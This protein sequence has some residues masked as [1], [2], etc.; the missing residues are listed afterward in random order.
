MPLFLSYS[1]VLTPALA[2]VLVAGYA[3]TNSSV[4]PATPAQAATN[5]LFGLTD[6]MQL[7]YRLL[8][9]KGKTVGEINQRVVHLQQG[10]R[11]ESKK[12]MVPEQTAL[13]KS[14]LYDRKNVLIR[15]QDLTFRARRDTSFT[16]G[17][18]Y[19]NHDAM[20]SFRDRKIVYTPVPVAWPD[21]PT[22]GTELPDGGVTV[23]VS[24][25][26]VDIATV[27][28]TLRKR[29][30]VS[31]PTPLTTPAGTFACY[32]VESVRE[33]ATV[34]RPDMA[35][36]NT[37]KQVDFYAPGVGIV[38]TEQ[39]TKSGKLS[40]VQELTIRNTEPPSSMQKVKYKTKK[41]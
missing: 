17:M 29:R 31:G 2:L 1:S 6:K 23:N 4:P 36:R 18:A 30:V 8:D 16:D 11:E 24:S 9:A 14:G 37:S 25:S 3:Q 41:S 19:L 22:V 7:G 5:Q 38:R 26:V 39:Y 35:M 13:L 15:L 40:Q 33:E 28:T 20:R 10:E 21:Q 32:K 34:P 27:S 12:Q